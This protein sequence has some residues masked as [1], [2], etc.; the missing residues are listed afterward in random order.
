MPRYFWLQEDRVAT[1]RHH[2]DFNAAHRWRL[3][4][5]AKCPGCGATWSSSGHMYP[6][7]DLSGLPEQDLFLKARSAPFAEFARLREQVRPL[8]P[9]AATLPPG[10]RFG[11]LV[12][13][14]QGD[15]GPLSWQGSYLLL[16][17]RDTLEQLQAE[18]VRGLMGVRAELR[19]RQ[20]HP[21]EMLELQLE[22]GGLLHPQCLPPDL[23]LACATC[24]RRGL[25]LPDEPLLEGAT[26]PR[27]RDVFRLG[28]YATVL[29][30]TERFMEAVRR[31]RLEGI[32][33]QELS[34]R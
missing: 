16:L 18:G 1:A 32:H 21:P 17:R 11:P 7:V 3:P 25:Q 8:A 29:V 20:K 27:D 12:G 14:A 24:G 15:L 33:F 2:G 9:P 30:G 26:L 34:T 10:T 5:L 22:P 28:N 4:G 31:L 13:T 19:F 23:P 6:S